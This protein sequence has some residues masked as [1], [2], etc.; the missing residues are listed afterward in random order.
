MLYK[1]INSVL[2]NY[3]QKKKQWNVKNVWRL[4]NNVLL[5]KLIIF[6]YEKNK[7]EKLYT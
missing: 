5:F 6:K 7:N 1:E 2:S 4:K 3:K